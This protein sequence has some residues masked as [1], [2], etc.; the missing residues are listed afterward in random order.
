M[1]KPLAVVS[2][3]DH[4]A[5]CAWSSRPELAGDSYASFDQKVE[6]CSETH[7]PLILAGD[8][9]DQAYPD[10]YTVG[11]F[12]DRITRLRWESVQVIYIQGQHE[13]NKKRPWLD[14]GPGLH[15]LHKQWFFLPDGASKP[16][17]KFYGLDFQPAGKLK[18]ELA[19]I[20]A[21][22]E[23]LVAHQVWEER[24][25]K[26]A[27]PEAAFKDVPTVKCIITGDFH[28][29][30]QQHFK[31]ADDQDILVVSPGSQCM[32]DLSEDPEKYFF[33]MY[34]DLTFESIKLK[35]RHRS[36]FTLRNP[37]S[38][39]DDLAGIVA[40]IE[41][42]DGLPEELVKPIYMVEYSEAIPDAKPRLK[43]ALADK[44]H[45][46]AR[47]IIVKKVKEKTTVT[48]GLSLAER[49]VARY[50][51]TD[52]AVFNTAKRLLEA[53]DVKAEINNIGAEFLELPLVKTTPFV[54]PP[55]EPDDGG[56]GVG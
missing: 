47:P 38:F 33:V 12:M 55:E 8:V 28:G 49:I 42:D 11:Y 20:P 21:G 45:L 40:D 34:D 15:H 5:P 16:R 24:M 37:G 41:Y 36:L 52:V 51:K 27:S 39:E 35:T 25:G 48:L 46:F 7:L 43:A 2:S 3:D 44:V 13:F 29:H 1:R 23:V 17:V 30:G 53:R 26:L 32:Q 4:L 54:S 18:A 19:Q 56:L 10:P 6:Y 14:L 9:L 22:T 31:G 50:S